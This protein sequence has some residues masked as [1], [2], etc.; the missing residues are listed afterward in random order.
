[1]AEIPADIRAVIFDMDGVIVDSEHLHY[2]TDSR[3]FEH[4]S[5]M[6]QEKERHQFVGMSV[7]KFYETICSQYA[8][9]LSPE[10][11]IEFDRKYR[12]WFFRHA[13]IRAND[14]ITELLNYLKKQKIKTA[15]ASGSSRELIE[16]ILRRLG[17]LD[18]FDVVLS[19][20]WVPRPKPWPDVFLRAAEL[21][22]TPPDQ[23]MVIEDSALGIQASRAAG[24]FSIG[25]SGKNG[26]H[27][28]LSGA[29]RTIESFLSLFREF[30]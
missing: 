26:H 11:M 7:Q 28:D 4:F 27:Q 29:D 23:C 6:V 21:L 9:H 22:D 18:A 3:I 1:M 14:Q 8:P 10:Y 17:L 5:I 2:E 24:M 13:E 30:R 20:E 16:I 19:S 25:Y 15:L 12:A